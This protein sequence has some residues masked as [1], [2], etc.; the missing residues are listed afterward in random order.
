MKK[1][2]IVQKLFAI[3]AAAALSLSLF[4][5]NG[6]CP[7]NRFAYTRTGEPGLNYLCKGYY[8]FFDHAAPY[9]DFMRNELSH[10][11]PP[12]NVMEWARRRLARS[13]DNKR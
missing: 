7:R 3:A 1:R 13:N 9:M 2:S 12:S 11:R 5:C 4:A 6:E 8:K 10:R